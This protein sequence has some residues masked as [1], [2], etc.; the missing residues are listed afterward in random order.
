MGRTPTLRRPPAGP[1]EDELAALGG[2][3]REG[4]W[5][6]AGRRVRVTNLDKV[7]VPATE[8]AEPP[9]TKRELIAYYARIAPFLLPYLANR[10]V[11]AHRY[12]DGVHRPGFWHK[13]VPDHAPRWLTRWH[14]T[15]ADP[16]ETQCYAV[17]DSLPALVWMANFAGVELHPWTSAL[18]DVHHPTWALVD[19][20]PGPRTTFD[21]VL[22]LARLY[23]DALAHL[24][25]AGM[26]KVTGQRGVQIW[27]PVRDGYTFDDTRGWVETVSRVIGRIEPDLVSWEWY[28]H[29]RGGLARLDYTQNAINKTLVAPFSVRP[30]PGA[31]VSVPITWDELEDPALRPDRWSIRTVLARVREVGDPLA[32]LIGRQQELPRL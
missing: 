3:G 4:L 16:D 11:N 15:E 14:N 25:V 18:P 22:A 24:D 26:P 19:I 20:D 31:P 2:F 9:V 12:P 1:T 13:E 29:R 23:R 27:I 5:T 7:L 30:R 8:S 32:G 17:L 28:R 21:E 6:V 10:P